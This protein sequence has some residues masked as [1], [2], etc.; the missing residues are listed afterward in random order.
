MKACARCRT[1]LIAGAEPPTLTTFGSARRS[2][3]SRVGGDSVAVQPPRNTESTISQRIQR[4][5][6]GLL[7]TESKITLHL[8]EFKAET[9]PTVVDAWEPGPSLNTGGVPLDYIQVMCDPSSSRRDEAYDL[10]R[11]T[12][13]DPAAN[14]ADDQMIVDQD[15]LDLNL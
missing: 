4:R 13:I 9:L 3:S 11:C 12:T 2:G 1:T 14:R 6:H 7:K 10:W 5:L 15:L 8:G